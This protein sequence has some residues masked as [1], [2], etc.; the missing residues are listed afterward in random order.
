MVFLWA[1]VCINSTSYIKYAKLFDISYLSMKRNNK[2]KGRNIMGNSGEIKKGRGM[3]TKLFKKMAAL[4]LSLAIGLSGFAMPTFAATLDSTLT[5]KNVEAG[6][7]VKGY[8]IV[9]ESNGKWVVGK[10]GITIADPSKPTASE[11][12]AIASAGDF[13]GLDTV[14]FNASGS[15]YVANSPKAGIYL[16]MVTPAAGST[17]VYT[18][19]IVSA[20]YK[21]DAGEDK[22]SV[23]D[24]SDSNKQFKIGTTAYAKKSTP[25]VKKEVYN[26][27]ENDQVTGDS[28]KA[29]D[30]HQIGDKVEFKI[31]T[32]I[33]L[34]T[35]DYKNPKFEISDTLSTGLKLDQTSIKVYNGDPGATTLLTENTDYTIENKTETGFTVKFAKTFLLN[36][37]DKSKINV[38]YKAQ[39][40]EE[41]KSGFDPS[42]NTAT[43]DY[44]TSPTTNDGKDTDRTKHYTFDINGDVG[45]KLNQT[46]RK[47]EIVKVGVDDEGNT[48]TDVVTSAETTAS[49]GKKA[50]AKFRLYKKDA[51]LTSAAD[52]KNHEATLL[53]RRGLDAS[54]NIADES[55][56]KADGKIRF[57]GI[58]AG[59][60]VLVE[61]EAPA[62]YAKNETL[63]PVKISA[64]LDAEGNLK[65]YTVTINGVE[66]GKYVAT[67]E[68]DVVKTTTG[69]YN[70]LHFNNYKLGTLPSTGGIG[71]YLFYIV[72]AALLSLAVAMM[73]KKNKS[74]AAVK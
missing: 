20:D 34:Y 71:T 26:K 30:T 64:E 43:I 4:A 47:E 57:R 53:V 33:P 63:V 56:T 41:A 1:N 54:D 49:A 22:S 46:N 23:L 19:M 25:K 48:V 24:V 42:T 39:L 69:T 13:S 10:T 44:S 66:A 6:A 65:S 45:T 29:G 38:T 62:G 12:Y 5:I 21:Q 37:A 28:T 59:E 32:A 18:P 15:K 27:T 31:G 14:T 16:V 35:S 52:Y 51:T 74:N 67:Y 9:K 50:G 61:T 73:V 55:E 58:D 17:G 7:T 70:P 40:T 68:N 36:S 72:G 60:Y 3:S 11:I 8:R 2:V